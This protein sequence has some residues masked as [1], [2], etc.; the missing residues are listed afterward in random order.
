MLARATFLSGGSSRD[1]LASLLMWLL[2]ASSSFWL[3]SSQHLFPQNHQ[4][5]RGS[6]PASKLE[7]VEGDVIIGHLIT[8]ATLYWLESNNKFCS[9][10][11]G[12]DYMWITGGR[13]YR[14]HL[15]SSALFQKSLTL[16]SFPAPSHSIFLL[17]ESMR[18]SSNLI[19]T[20]TSLVLLYIL[21][22]LTRMS[23]VLF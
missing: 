18:K 17:N 16:S 1:R 10:L 4:S 21:F 5:K 12:E 11:R 3:Q 8:C 20:F 13:D 14:G 9:H 6:E 22:C 19:H 2:A 23:F 15:G 7:F